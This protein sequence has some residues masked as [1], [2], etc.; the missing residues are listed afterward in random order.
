MVLRKDHPPGVENPDKMS[1]EQPVTKRQRIENSLC[2]PNGNM[3][4]EI[5]PPDIEAVSSTSSSSS[6]SSSQPDETDHAHAL[7]YYLDPI[8]LPLNNNNNSS[9]GSSGS[10]VSVQQSKNGIDVEMQNFKKFLMKQCLC[11]VSERTL[12][13]PFQSHISYANGNAKR[14][15][16]LIEWPTNKLLQFL[17]N[18]Q[19]L[20]DVYLKQNAN[21]NICGRIKDVCDELILNENNLIM[22]IIELCE[23]DNKYIQFLAG[24][25]MA[26]FLVMAKDSQYCSDWLKKLVDN[27]FTF[28]DLN[29]NAVRKI[30]FSLDIF[31][32]IVEWKDVETHPL[33]EHIVDTI[34]PPPIENNYFNINSEISRSGGDS[35]SSS[36]RQSLIVEP[37]RTSRTNRPALPAG[38]DM[39]A[40]PEEVVCEL[41]HL[42]DSES[43]DTTNLKCETVKILENK[44]PGLL[45]NMSQLISGYN[46][47]KY[48][49]NTI[50]TFLTLWENIISVQANLSVVDT[51]PFHAQLDAFEMLLKSDLPTTIYKQMLTLFNEALCYGSTLALQDI[52]PDETCS[53]AHRIINHVKDGSRLLYT[54]PRKHPENPISFIGYV[55]ENITYSSDLLQY[56]SNENLHHEDESNRHHLGGYSSAPQHVVDT[57]CSRQMDKILLQKIVLLVLKSVAVSVR[58][59]RSD[60]SDSS[61]DSTDYQAFSDMILIEQNMREVLKKLD[62]FIK[63]KMEFHPESHFSRMLIVL[64]DEQDDYLIEA[65]VCTLDVTAGFSFKNNAFPELISLLN[66]VFTFLEFLKMISNSSNLLL[67]LL[68]SNE[69]CFLLY[70]LRFLKYIRINWSMF[71]ESCQMFDGGNGSTDTL[72]E[73][74]SVL[75]RL[76]LQISRLVSRSL[77]PYDISPILR[78]LESCEN[79]YEGN[80]LS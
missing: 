17:S 78:L 50:L 11:G 71:C 36:N 47:M 56:E 76:R 19:L 34:S 79:L 39:A 55:G 5:E 61:I 73:T 24:K 77:Y 53:L 28:E 22:E 40:G 12:K 4:N 62:M 65:M 29:Y 35:G 46:E 58:E 80:E 64:F 43:F 21:G 52:I 44:W 20:F 38:L 48:S 23:Y 49:E 54:L 25:M 72:S 57:M 59:M 42:T 30:S 63:Q 69:T 10:N 16:S 14:I 6:L 15:L 27:L 26:S 70:L 37:S 8:I 18:L 74:M 33:D 45:K 67:D 9:G 31:K 32:R 66:P 51:H 41:E 1:N 2:T 68:V 7:E 3:V 75:I 60:S 13:R